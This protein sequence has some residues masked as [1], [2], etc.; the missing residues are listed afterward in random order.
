MVQGAP[1][2]AWLARRASWP[3]WPALM[4]MGLTFAFA[5]TTRGPSLCSPFAWVA[6]HQLRPCLRNGLSPYL[7][8]LQRALLQRMLQVHTTGLI[9][10]TCAARCTVLTTLLRCSMLSLLKAARTD[11]QVLTTLPTQ[12]RVQARARSRKQAQA[13]TFA[14]PTRTT[15]HSRIQI[16]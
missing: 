15:R 2:R 3:A 9:L 8:V 14:M 11:N 4:R 12:A 10:G 7:N 16:C 5:L 13:P 1:T 6:R